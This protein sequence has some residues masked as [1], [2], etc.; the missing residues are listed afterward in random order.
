MKNWTKGQTCNAFGHRQLSG[1]F[2]STS[3]PI[4]RLSSNMLLSVVE[5]HIF[6]SDSSVR[7]LCYFK[8]I[9]VV[10]CICVLP[11]HPICLF[12]YSF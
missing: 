12:V 6:T 7:K 9:F 8:F 2:T 5:G 3:V 1:A 4:S 11:L 10:F